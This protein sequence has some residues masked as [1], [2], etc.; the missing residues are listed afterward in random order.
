[1]AKNMA[2][3][4]RS[5]SASNRDRGGHRGVASRNYNRPLSATW[6]SGDFP[7]ILAM[8]FVLSVVGSAICELVRLIGAGSSPMS[9]WD[10][11]GTRSGKTGS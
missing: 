3:P 9:F 11:I 5:R 1:M 2:A 10:D 6:L 8:S 4:R 7:R